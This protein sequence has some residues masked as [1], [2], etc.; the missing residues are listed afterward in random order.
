MGMRQIKVLKLFS[1]RARQTIKY[2]CMIAHKTVK[3][4]TDNEQEVHGH[5]FDAEMKP[6]ILND[7]CMAKDGKWHETVFSFDT[8]NLDILPIL[9]VAAHDIGDHNEK[10]GLEIGPICFS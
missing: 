4:L 10:F 2:H 5:S 7:G 6:R 1:T 9:D 3:F 8:K